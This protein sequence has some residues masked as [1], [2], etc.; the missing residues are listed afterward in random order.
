MH[1]SLY[2]IAVSI[3]AESEDPIM[4]SVY[5]C[6]VSILTQLTCSKLRLAI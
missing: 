3:L 1:L 2:D 5:E 4:L 6:S